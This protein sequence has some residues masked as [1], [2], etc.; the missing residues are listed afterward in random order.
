MT[1]DT[2][3]L[4][5]GFPPVAASTIGRALAAGL[6]GLVVWEAFARFVA[7][8]WIG[9]PLDATALIEMSFGVSG[10]PA[11][12][13]H[14]LTGVAFYPLGYLFIVRPLAL[15]LMPGM[16]WVGL[17]LAYG[18]GLWVFAMFVMASLIGGAPAFLGFQPVAWASLLG[19][20]AMATT[21]VGVA[22]ILLSGEG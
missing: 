9:G 21:I 12:L 13:L 20:L 22:E 14:V 6:A 5:A 18:A 10:F 11:L 8:L 19:H 17:G 4:H 1:P 7:P 2:N 16:A 3:T 15:R